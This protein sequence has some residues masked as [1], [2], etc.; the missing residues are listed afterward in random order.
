MNVAA[1]RQQRADWVRH[2][3]PAIAAL[4]DRVVFLDGEPLSAIGSRTM[5]SAVK[6]NLTRLRG[7]A[8]RGE[9]LTMDAPFG[10]WIRKR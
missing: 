5:A 2:R 10:S 1:L 4:P 7:R 8:L 6:T 3:L 9:W